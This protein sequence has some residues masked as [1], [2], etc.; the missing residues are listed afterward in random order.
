MTRVKA[1]WLHSND[2]MLYSE[3]ITNGPARGP[4]DVC[5]GGCMDVLPSGSVWEGAMI[6][7][8]TSRRHGRYCALS[9]RLTTRPLSGRPTRPV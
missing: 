5:V 3:W 1:A 4:S 8:M 9:V 6:L 2:L 7:R